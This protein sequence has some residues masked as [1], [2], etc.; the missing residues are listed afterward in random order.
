MAYPT[1]EFPTFVFQQVNH[2]PIQIPDL[3]ILSYDE[4]ID[5]L[6]KIE[7]DSFDERYSEDE[8]DQ[9]N[10][11][12]SLLPIEGA[13]DD[14]KEEIEYAV[15][16]LF[17]KDD[18]QYAVFNPSAGYTIKPAIHIEGAH[19]FV[20]CKSWFKKQWDQTRSFVEK[21]KKA[22]IIGAIVGVSVAVVAVAAVAISSSAA[23]VAAALAGGAVA[24][25]EDSIGTP[26]GSSSSTHER[27]GHCE[28]KETSSN[29]T[30]ASSLQTQVS[31]FKETIA[32]QQFAAVSESNG[33]SMEENGRIIGSLFAHKAVDSLSNSF[34]QN[35]T[36]ATELK[37]FG[38]NSK[39]S[40]PGWLQTYPD[41]SAIMLHASSAFSRAAS[42]CK[43]V[44]YT[45]L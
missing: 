32:Q 15:A 24:G 16:C 10:Q 22:I 6:G 27:K 44:G 3:R 40:T 14:E 37:D 18:I 23:S 39:Y 34:A 13:T 33:I 4:V 2:Q 20:L 21:H 31:E 12:V 38:F 30:L 8:L 45:P 5:L 1:N 25:A 42:T 36:F 43:P 11:F 19:D 29:D 7:S 17:R 41:S 28:P 35:P 9:I 26:N